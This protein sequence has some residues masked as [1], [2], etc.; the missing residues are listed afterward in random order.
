[1]SPPPSHHAAKAA[2]V[3]GRDGLSEVSIVPS[4]SVMVLIKGM[5]EVFNFIF[6]PLSFLCS[7]AIKPVSLEAREHQK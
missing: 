2:L 4:I 3:R 7:S 1:M 5:F 6:L